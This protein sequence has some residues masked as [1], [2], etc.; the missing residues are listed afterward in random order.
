MKNF[1]KILNQIAKENGSTPDSVLREMELALNEAYDRRSAEEQ[2][3][4]DMLAF[5]G[6]RP[7]PEEFIFQIAMM[8]HREDGMFRFPTS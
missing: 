8:L 6:E 3:L 2:S 4:W 7:T 1:Q 5:K